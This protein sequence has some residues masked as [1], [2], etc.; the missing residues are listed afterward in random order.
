MPEKTAATK[1]RATRFEGV[2]M[3]ESATRRHN[4]K[5]DISYTIDYRD[6]NG[7]RIR[8]DVGWASEGFSAQYVAQLRQKLIFEAKRDTSLSLPSPR[9]R[10]RL[11]AMSGIGWSP[12][13]KGRKT[14]KICIIITSRSWEKKGCRR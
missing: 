14:I 8:K 9:S 5:P 10:N 11:S 4:G 2:Y 3:R 13:E 7:R 1:R 12:G 6:A